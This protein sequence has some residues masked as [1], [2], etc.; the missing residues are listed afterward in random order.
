M[1]SD[2]KISS[3]RLE[4]LEAKIAEPSSPNVE[5]ESVDA[6]KSS[7]SSALKSFISGGV[8]GACAVLVGHPLDLVKV[9]AVL[10]Q[11]QTIYSFLFFFFESFTRWGR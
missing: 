4:A 9:C 7:S 6:P 1:A 8:G 5:A 11:I 3:G 10:S 2:P